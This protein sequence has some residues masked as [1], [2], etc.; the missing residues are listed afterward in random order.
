MLSSMETNPGHRDDPDEERTALD[1]AYQ[2]RQRLTSGLRLPA[3]FYRLLA[4]A[5]AVQLGAAAY[6]I[7]AQTAAGLAVLMAGL[8]V[9]LGVAALMLHRFR[10]INGVRVD[11]L[12]R[13]IVLSAGASASLLY[14]GALAV[15]IWA[16]FASLWW[17]V[18][19]AAVFGGVGCALG[20]RRWWHAYQDDPAAHAD[21]V[22]PRQLG[23][24]ALLA[25]LGFAALVVL[26]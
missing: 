20:A 8:A 9:F 17:L 13:Q 21:G 26:G 11:G 10:L 19:V 16:A 6:G 12:T 14:L 22:S 15:G 23:V 7:A 5:V 2:V 24:L 3:G 1:L 25:S 4:A 18:A